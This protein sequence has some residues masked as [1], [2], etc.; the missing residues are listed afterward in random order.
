MLTLFGACVVTFMMLMYALEGRA[1]GFVLA[2]AAGCALSSTYGFL[3][4]T[5]PFGI[6]EAIWSLV[7]VKRYLDSRAAT[8]SEAPSHR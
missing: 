7:A 5:W 6:V 8:R 3:A 2:F 1:P 4:G